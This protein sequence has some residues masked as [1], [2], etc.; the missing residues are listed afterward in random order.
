M[1]RRP[2]KAIFD[3]IR[4]KCAPGLW[5]LGVK[6]AREGSVV[7]D[8]RG[9]AQIDARVRVPLKPVPPSVTL[10]P[11]DAEWTCDCGGRSD[12]CEHVAAVVIAAQQA[13][14]ESAAAGEGAS[15]STDTSPSPSRSPSTPAKATR[16][17]VGYRLIR[18]EQS[19]YLHRSIVD[20]V[21]GEVPLAVGL[22]SAIARGVAATLLAEH[23]DLLLDRLLQGNPRAFLPVARMSEIFGLLS[24]SRDVK[25]DGVPVR[26]SSAPIAPRAVVLDE[27]NSVVLRIERDP[28]VAEVIARGAVRVRDEGAGAAAGGVLHVIHPM[29][30]VELTG[31]LLDKLPRTRSFD[32]SRVAELVTDVLPS[33]ESRLE[34]EVRS[35][36]LPKR[37]RAI[38]PRIL[39]E[40]GQPNFRGPEGL[41]SSLSVVPFLVYGDPPQARIHDGKLVHLGGDVP[42]RDESAEKKLLARLRD[43]LNLVPGRR[44]DLRGR[45]AIQFAARLKAWAVHD[46]EQSILA[47]RPLQPR[48]EEQAGD[49]A[50]FDVVFE[51]EATGDAPAKTASASAVVRAW[52]EGLDLVP[53][54]GGGWAP[55]PLDWLE[56]HG[57]RLADLMAAKDA[58]GELPKS[59]ALQ[60]ARLCEALDRPAPPSFA[61]LAETLA[62]FDRIPAAALPTD[63]V[64][65]LRP[66]QRAG[67]DWL[68]FLRDSELG[69]VLAD[70]MGLGKTLQAIATLRG[71]ALVV[72]PK[73]VVHNWADEIAK[74]RPSLRVAR[75]HGARR[76]LDASA[77]V[78]ITTYA[79][80][81]LDIDTLEKV[82]WD[83]VVLDEAQAIKNPDSQAA[84]A[85]YR[86]R[87]PFRVALSGTPV[88]NRLDE[89]WSLF[90]FASP[91]L[92]G[93]RN[94]FAE[95]FAKPIAEGEPGAAARLR[96]ILRPFLLRRLKREVAQDLPPRSDF[97]LRVDLDE[98]ERAVYDAV[99]AATKKEL[100]D[101]LAESGNVLAA[102][103]ALLR[104][105]QAA[106]HSGLVPGQKADT[107]SK[108]ELLVEKLVD[109]AADGHKALVFSQWTSMLDRI[110]PHLAREGIAFTR[111]DGSTSDRA[112]VVARFQAED[113]PPVM[114]VS[115]KAGGT[116]LNLTAADHVFLVDP[117]WNPAVEDQAADRA[118]RI[119]QDKPIFVYRLVAA[120]TVE[121]GILALQ[122]KKRAIADAALADGSAAASITRDELLALLA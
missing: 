87:A 1:L 32:P 56:K 12:P 73:S 96:E 25:L 98:Q 40:L 22:A 26:L 3:A 11:P 17:H 101:R 75:Y 38:K 60:V 113:G 66:Y 64:A 36:R 65:T 69:A 31:D 18:K 118:H 121:E 114:L 50:R 2:V 100:L 105:R 77:D 44:V 120:D 8:A 14:G 78:T 43:D 85:A 112:G 67:I 74:F 89:L 94:D 116:G 52:Q 62:N 46:P 49:G 34:I 15:A 72:C 91:G 70:D 13:A 61:K 97:V 68:A 102:L 76:A 86:L 35:R 111:L 80:A 16:S 7:F 20:D 110:E 84:R 117:W 108:V 21:G 81:R 42:M 95:R 103:E 109:A 79:V 88:E 6:L 37:A 106:C 55:L 47:S 59:A 51:A 27:G 57:R 45:D 24:G 23:D 83:A 107:S 82:R 39:L 104:L 29:G 115:L 63:L 41:E 93:G 58:Q 92:L 19:L 53:L 48:L 28:R 90:H 99:R 30:E 10:Y 9:D 5:T 54:D 71:R 122:Q 33:L 4:K 119:G